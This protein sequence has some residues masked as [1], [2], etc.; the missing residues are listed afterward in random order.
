MILD[1]TWLEVSAAGLMLMGLAVVLRSAWAIHLERLDQ[2]DRDV[3][4]EASEVLMWTT[5]IEYAEQQG[6]WVR[7]QMREKIRERA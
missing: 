5:D 1:A 7:E 3:A 4:L 6:Q 2:E